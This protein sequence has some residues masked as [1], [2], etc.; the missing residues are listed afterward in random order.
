MAVHANM[1]EEMVALKDAVLFNHPMILVRNER[2]EDRGCDVGMI[3]RAERVSN[4]VKEGAGH[5]LVVA[6]VASW[7]GSR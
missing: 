1:V 2:L 6:A 5:V 7:P 4:V 3:E